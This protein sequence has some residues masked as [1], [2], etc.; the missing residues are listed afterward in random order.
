MNWYFVENKRN[1]FCLCEAVELSLHKSNN[2]N[3][4][5]PASPTLCF[6]FI[7]A[8]NEC[9]SWLIYI[10]QHIQQMMIV[11]FFA[12]IVVYKN[13][14][15]LG[16]N[17]IK[18]YISGAA[19]VWCDCDTNVVFFLAQ[20]LFHDKQ[21]IHYEC[22]RTRAAIENMGNINTMCNE[23]FNTSWMDI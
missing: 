10:T 15:W 6:V 8:L 7:L 21:K 14:I 5:I 16:A 3:S 13:S 1:S 2:N 20:P 11:Y 4:K 12:I 18:K 17:N 9:V 23:F 22:L 19:G